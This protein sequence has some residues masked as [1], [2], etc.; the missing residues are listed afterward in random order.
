MLRC[1]RPRFEGRYYRVEEALNSPAPLQPGGVP[2]L[3]GGGGEK[4][5]LRLV[6]RYANE[7]NLTCAPEEIP[8]KLEALQRHCRELGRE[9]GEINVTWLGSLVLGRTQAAAEAARNEFLLRR[10]MRW[11]AL[12]EAIRERIGAALVLGDPDRVGEF[13]RRELLDRGLDGVI[14]NLPANGH[15]LEAIALAGETLRKV[16]G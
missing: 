6:A 4:R 5:T 11:E 16:I 1:E 15:D 2:I 13:V 12:P 3:I 8:R 10:G 14:F 7:S 9:R